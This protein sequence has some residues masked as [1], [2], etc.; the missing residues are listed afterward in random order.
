MLKKQYIKS[1]KVC[2]VTFE[3]PDAELPEPIVADSVHL[4]GEFNDWDPTATPMPR[5]RGG[6][7]RVTL[8]LEPGREYQFRY[9][10]N[11]EH[12]CN[13]WHA[14]AYVS[15]GFGEDNCVVVTPA[16]A[17]AAGLEKR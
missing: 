12:W 4:V 7:Y 2:K 6:I 10:V 9:L 8:E 3:L 1:R 5:G 15:G 17:S 14:D 13:D 11:G 16:Q